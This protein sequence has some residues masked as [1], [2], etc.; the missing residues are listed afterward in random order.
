[1][2]H[3]NQRPLRSMHQSRTQQQ[4]F[5]VHVID[6]SREDYAGIDS[7][8]KWMLITCFG[9]TGYRNAKFW[10]NH[11]TQSSFEFGKTPNRTAHFDSC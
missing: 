10:Q 2:V 11:R 7:V 8:L 5:A 3:I 9:H 6:E 4:M 1:M